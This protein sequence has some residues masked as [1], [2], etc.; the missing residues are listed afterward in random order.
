ME[1]TRSPFLTLPLACQGSST[2]YAL[3]T[4]VKIKPASGEEYK[5]VRV[6]ILGKART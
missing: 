1:T 5:R 6:A 3:Q 4:P 2:L